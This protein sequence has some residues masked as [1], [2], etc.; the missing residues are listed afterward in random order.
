MSE[1]NHTPPRPV[2]P[3]T[4]ERLARLEGLVDRWLSVPEA[5]DL[6]GLRQSDVRRQLKEGDLIGVRRGPNKALAIPAD[7]VTP[8]GPQPALRGTVTVLIDGG[9]NEVEVVDWLFSPD[10][11]LPV[12]GSPM[13]A[14]LA[15]F[16]T[17][18]RRRAMETAF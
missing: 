10:D 2:D 15:G 8:E 13:N 9:M 17:E 6:Q 16:K 14:L 18:V 1:S 12:P 4:A 7:F 5:A 11:S 3:E